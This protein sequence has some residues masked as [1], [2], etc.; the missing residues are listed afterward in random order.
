[1]EIR[2][3][4][5][6]TIRNR[7][8]FE[9]G[10]SNFEFRVSIFAF[11][12]VFALAS[13]GVPGDPHPLKPAV[14][15][16]ITD[17]AARQA[18]DGAL[19]TFTLPATTL[20]GDKL[21]KFP[22]LEIVRGF[23]PAAAKLPPPASALRIIYTVP[24]AVVDTYLVQDRVEFSD[25]LKPEE[26][27]AH[28]GQRLV[29]LVR[30]RVSKKQASPD[31]NLASVLLLPAPEPIRDLRA[32]VVEAGVSLEWTPPAR[33][34]GGQPL[35][36]LTGYRVYR[37]E[38]E[39]LAADPS[40]LVP[41]SPA[42]LVGVM[43]SPSY[44]DAQIE[45]GHSYSYTVRSVAQYPA[46]SVESSDS[47]AVRVTPKDIFP[48]APPRDLVAVYVPAAGDSAASVELSWAISTEADLAGYNVY[49]DANGTPRVRL[50]RELLL[51]PTFRDMSV[52]V[53]G[54]YTY[55]VTAV[56][57]AGN[58]SRSS[59]GVTTAIPKSGE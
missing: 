51:T 22:D 5:A 49:R 38:L 9:G 18:G 46:N 52:V 30:S 32:A 4:S 10:C 25:P 8:K 36:S 40:Q 24:S 28:S 19:L 53:G 16:A 34:S 21:D 50:N 6:R 33:T 47:S 2:N 39:A 29:Y 13:C 14:P 20:D 3:S 57:R 27:A 7:D 17:L 54:Q 56:D 43:A 59:A 58:E 26:V 55:T 35:G 1:M 41:K 48:P 31:S 12:A 44:V 42:S 15:V 37:A 23:L 45:W 11:L